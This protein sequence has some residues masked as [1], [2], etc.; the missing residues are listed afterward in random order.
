[1]GRPSNIVSKSAKDCVC[2]PSLPSQSIDG[3]E[4]KTALFN[5][6]YARHDRVSLHSLCTAL[7]TVKWLHSMLAMQV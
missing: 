6:S 4:Y 3:L 1:M 7:G 5:V 2:V